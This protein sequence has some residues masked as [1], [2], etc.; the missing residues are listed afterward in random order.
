MIIIGEKLNSS[1]PSVHRAFEERD[2]SYIKQMT[3]KQIDCGADY[4]DV[5]AGV[6]LEKE[7]ETLLW[8]ISHVLEEAPDARLMID[9]P[10]PAAVKE[11]L[12]VYHDNE[13][14]VNSIT[15]EEDRLPV[16]ETVCEYGTG[17]V[18]L[19]IDENG[20][21]Q[22]AEERLEVSERLIHMLRGAGIADD[23]IY[24]DILVQAISSDHMAGLETLKSVKL[25]REHFP[26]VHLTGGLSN[27]S[28]GLPG[29]AYINAAFLA[30][31][32][33]MGLDS[34]ITDVTNNSI[35]F[36]IQ[37]ALLINGQDEYCM[38]YIE[39]YRDVFDD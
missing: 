19:P 16:L 32:I 30:S 38:N 13:V 25:L 7:V 39:Q 26:D 6:F 9:S 37:S 34:A 35:R 21:P 3:A 5:N 1:I 17:I 23:R 2:A 10:S 27:I 24:L 28:F 33:T 4:L 12:K 14:I 20:I 15:L 22:T 31:A 29:R 11:V 36:A 8:A 18:A